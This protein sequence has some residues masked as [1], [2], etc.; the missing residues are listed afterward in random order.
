MKILIAEDELTARAVLQNMLQKDAHE[1][2]ATEDGQQA[3]DQLIQHHDEFDLLI[4]DIMMPVMDGLELLK[5]VSAQFPLLPVIV[6]TSKEGRETVK[7]ALKL[8]ASDFLDKPID[9]QALSEAIA[10]IEA[11]T[12]RQELKKTVQ[13]SQSVRDAQSMLMRS[14][15]SPEDLDPALISY[16]FKP[17]SDAGGDLFM[18]KR[19]DQHTY[20]LILADMAGHDVTSS[21]IAA[22]FKGLVSGL[23]DHL[24]SP[25]RFLTEL[26]NKLLDMN[27]E[28]SHVCALCMVWNS[29]T[30]HVE[31]ANAGLPHPYLL[32]PG[33]QLNEI[34]IDGMLL[35]LFPDAVFDRISLRLQ[36]RER[37][38]L[39]SDG[40][41]A[42]ENNG[43]LRIAWPIT[44][45]VSPV[46]DALD[47]LIEQLKLSEMEAEDDMI[48]VAIEEPAYQDEYTPPPLRTCLDVQVHSA[49]NLVEPIL[50]HLA[51][52]LGHRHR[53]SNQF[54]QNLIFATREIIV[55]A[56]RHGNLSIPN[57]IVH[58]LTVADDATQQITI[59]IQDQ[60]DGFDLASILADEADAPL[61]REGKRGIIGAAAFAHSIEVEGN[62]VTLQF[63]QMPATD[64]TV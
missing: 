64:D 54:T 19:L 43:T 6:L 14:S 38:L 35:G 63:K 51:K 7:Q 25:K 42:L 57:K 26:N 37:I 11:D 10:T 55:N 15:A 53:F 3:L 24:A 8:G 31:L 12:A 4:T 21:Y 20:S 45:S 47:A 33:G 28:H 44:R 60:G 49:I 61:L 34:P 58:I 41:D 40:M 13:T 1:V 22:Q 50:H 27:I 32:Y 5:H 23:S 30:G 2:I 62:Q 39:F 36:P 46:S 59:T 17:I 29:Q 56:I 18:C 9:R 16:W 52:F 48:L